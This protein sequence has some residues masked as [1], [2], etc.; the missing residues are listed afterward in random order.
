MAGTFIIGETKI[1][2]G[3]YFNIQ[4]VGGN[5][6][7]GADDGTTAVFF[8]A[9]FGPLNEVVEI[10][11]GDGY[12][13]V[14]GTAGT[15]DA[16]REVLAAGVKKALCCRVGKGG[17]VANTK[18]KTAGDVPPAKDA[19]SITAKHPGTK[20]FSIEVREKLSDTSLKECIIY[21]G[22]KEFEKFEFAVGEEEDEVK[23]LAAAFVNS[24]N[25]ACEI[26]DSATG[27]LAETEITAFTP[28]TDP[29]V[30]TEDYSTAFS[31]AEAYRFNTACVDTE[32][33][34]VHLLLAS[35]IDRIFNAGQLGLAIVAEKNTVSLDDR[36][37]HAAG[38]NSEK[39]HYVVNASVEESGEKV[40]GYMVAARIAGLIAACPSNKSLTHS[41][42]SGFTKLVD[43]L[44][45]TQITNAEKKGCIVLSTNTTG[46]IWI[47]SA[48]N[49]LVTPS[50]NQDDGWKK[51]RRTKTRYE[52]ITLCNDQADSL[53]G[54]VDN[55]TNGR[56]T[57]VSQ[58]QGIV[59]A[60]VNEGKL[61]SGTVTENTLYTS[62]GDYAYFDI[63]VID[64]DSIEHI[65]LTYKFQF[66]SRT[67]E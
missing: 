38:F 52:L 64:K 45:P 20:A 50:D 41:V 3:T 1:R 31:A 16:I 56:A 10:A 42:I 27:V 48:I 17:T 23:N 19:L 13:K 62:D 8:K 44:T 66:S 21:A 49:T 57:V 7:A 40:E 59:N 54:K 60:M 4:K 32:E 55:D 34:A 67:D 39:M 9:D 26:L 25:F 12:E 58:L 15:T 6:L 63:S 53:I 2:P 51:I 30:S 46:Q 5:Q 22:T 18:L 37:D 28:G 43:V 61:V 33:T 29:T 47:D 36:M 11:P 35:F 14:F 24:Q 65:Y